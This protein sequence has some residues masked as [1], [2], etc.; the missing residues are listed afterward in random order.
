[1]PRK[2]TSN[3]V[4]GPDWHLVEWMRTLKV[5]QADIMR[6]TGCGKAR[7]S[8]IANGKTNYYREIVNDLARVLKVQ[9]YELL[10]APEEAMAIRRMRESALQIAADNRATFT[11][12]PPESARLDPSRRTG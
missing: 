10:M 7:M 3:T 12:A 6:E 11:P 1:M 8:E 9:P 4:I 5:S 2:R